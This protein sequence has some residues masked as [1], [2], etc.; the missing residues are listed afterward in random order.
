MN[1]TTNRA[2]KEAVFQLYLRYVA[3]R[4]EGRFEESQKVGSL[5]LP[6]HLVMIPVIACPPRHQ[7]ALT[8]E[9]SGAKWPKTIGDTGELFINTNQTGGA[10]ETL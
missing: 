9:R 8:N 4:C 5:N 10:H 3:D 7:K 2:S 6:S 1:T